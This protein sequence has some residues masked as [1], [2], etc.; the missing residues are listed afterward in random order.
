[1]NDRDSHPDIGSDEDT[2]KSKEEKSVEEVIKQGI[3]K[4]NEHPSVHSVEDTVSQ[5]IP[6]DRGRFQSTEHMRHVFKE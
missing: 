5:F 3:A 4:A 6:S 1:M 2:K